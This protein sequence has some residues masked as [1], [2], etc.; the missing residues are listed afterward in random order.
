MEAKNKVD[1]KKSA[2]EAKGKKNLEAEREEHLH[3]AK[4]NPDSPVEYVKSGSPMCDSYM[5]SKGYDPN[6]ITFEEFCIEEGLAEAD[7][8]K[9]AEDLFGDK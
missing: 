1:P 3:P 5:I 7:A 8:L 2:E 9:E 6:T 4:G